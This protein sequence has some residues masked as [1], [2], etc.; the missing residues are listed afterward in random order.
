V[1]APAT[2]ILCGGILHRRGDSDG[3]RYICPLRELEAANLSSVCGGTEAVLCC[4]A[5]RLVT[6]QA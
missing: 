3:A 5:S 4:D 2:G 1:I 6:F